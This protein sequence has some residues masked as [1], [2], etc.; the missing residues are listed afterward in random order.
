MTIAGQMPP[1]K[2]LPSELTVAELEATLEEWFGLPVVLTS[3]GRGALRLAFSHLG[4]KR[5]RDRIAITPMISMCVL[6]AAIRH[7]FPIDAASAVEAEA[8][9]VY[10]Q[11]GF[12]QTVKPAG[13]VVEDICHSFYATPTRGRRAWLGELAAF[14]L[15][16]FFSTS[17]PV[18][19]L[20][21]QDRK[22]A[23][24][25]RALR[26]T[27]PQ[28]T[29]RQQDEESRIYCDADMHS[30]F[31]FDRLYLSR[32]VNSR[33][34]DRELGG[35]PK[36]VSEIADQGQ[37]RTEI[38]AIYCDAVGAHACPPGWHEM[39]RERLPYFFPVGGDEARLL[40]ARSRLRE[41]G[42]EAD[43]YSIDAARNMRAPKF[44]KMLLLPCHDKIPQDVL[45]EISVI[46]RSFKACRSVV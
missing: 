1:A 15:P 36:N 24:S 20:V 9:L 5:Y 6:E 32:L 10:H 40:N 7:A 23:A 34:S 39:I 13:P 25:V 28:R 19:G 41:I 29:V 4:L 42:V 22:R 18:G 3:S 2:Q 37:R 14:S 45:V 35:L 16:K 17:S 38:I 21:V 43:L 46:L 8:T 11:Y 44:I 33:I 30:H 12:V 26:D 27:Q 31:D